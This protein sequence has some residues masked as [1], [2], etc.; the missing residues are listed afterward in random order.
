MPNAAARWINHY[1]F[2]HSTLPQGEIGGV[3]SK[4]FQI[5]QPVLCNGAAGRLNRLATQLN[6][7]NF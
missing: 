3:P 7:R 4:K 2:G 5:G 6:T 1:H